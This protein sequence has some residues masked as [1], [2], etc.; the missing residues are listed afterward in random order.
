M[1]YACWRERPRCGS[2]SSSSKRSANS[3]A[4]CTGSVPQNIAVPAGSRAELGRAPPVRFKVGVQGTALILVQGQLP[5]GRWFGTL[6]AMSLPRPGETNIFIVVG[7]RRG[8]GTAQGDEADR[9]LL[10]EL[11]LRFRAMA[12]EDLE[13]LETAHYTPGTLTRHDEALARY[14]QMLRSFPRAN[15]AAEFIR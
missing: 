10:K 12:N 13:L 4:P 15:P 3:R 9:H 7:I 1:S 5:D 2:C 6:A 14:M 8:D 11:T